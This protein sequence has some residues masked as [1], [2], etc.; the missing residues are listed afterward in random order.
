MR[1]PRLLRAEGFT[2]VEY[3]IILCLIAVVGGARNAL[4]S[5]ATCSGSWKRKA[6]AAS[7]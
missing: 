2:T 7:G 6:C 3:I 5:A 1:E 4:T